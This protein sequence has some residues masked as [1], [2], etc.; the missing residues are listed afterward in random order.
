MSTSHSR[1]PACGRRQRRRQRR[2]HMGLRY[3]G[4]FSTQARPLIYF[5]RATVMRC[6]WG[7]AEEAKL[8]A[9]ASACME[10]AVFLAEK[11]AV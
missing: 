6:V 9:L 7:D 10:G 1:R 4:V 11:P 5:P 8:K 2:Q 3:A